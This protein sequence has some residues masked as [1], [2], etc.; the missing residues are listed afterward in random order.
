MSALEPTTANALVA[1]NVS[2]DGN[3]DPA[4]AE[5]WEAYSRWD[6][7]AIARK[8]RLDLSRIVIFV[9]L[10]A[11]ALTGVLASQLTLTWFAGIDAA[12]IAAAVLLGRGAVG[13]AVGCLWVTASAVGV[14]R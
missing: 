8:R 1:V 4:L 9:L 13:P 11:A 3:R 10:V 6:A 12:C 7:A 14:R 2:G 5:A